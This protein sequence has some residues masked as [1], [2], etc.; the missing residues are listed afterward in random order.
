MT[1]SADG[2][3][4]SIQHRRR[5]RVLGGILLILLVSSSFFWPLPSPNW[6]GKPVQA[7]FE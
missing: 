5:F 3:Q 4:P 7:W 2:R 6:K 1:I